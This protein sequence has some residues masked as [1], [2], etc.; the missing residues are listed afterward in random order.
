MPP[1]RS[2]R[3]SAPVGVA[4]PPS[5]LWDLPL[6][7]PSLAAPSS[8]RS[9]GGG[10]RSSGRGVTLAADALLLATPIDPLPTT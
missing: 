5:D 9:S 2:A 6:I 4:E 8:R 3:R 10:R 7:S 1:R